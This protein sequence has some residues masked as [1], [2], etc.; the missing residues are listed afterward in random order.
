[1]TTS[2]IR[3][4]SRTIEWVVG[5]LVLANLLVLL[6]GVAARYLLGRSPIWMDELSRFLIIG[7]AL[8]MAGVVWVRNEHMRIGL[9]E[10][11]LPAPLARLLKL[12][13]WL[14]ILLVSAGFCWYSWHYAFSVSRFTTMGLGISRTWPVLSLPLGFGLLFVFTLLRGPFGRKEGHA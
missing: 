8:L 4:L 13:Q 5:A 11:R 9:L 12:Y 7:C 10:Q 1:M 2:L 6:Y 14:L 3:Y